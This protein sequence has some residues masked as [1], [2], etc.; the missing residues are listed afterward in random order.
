MFEPGDVVRLRDPLPETAHD[1][2]VVVIVLSHW[3]VVWRSGEIQ[4]FN[5][6]SGDDLLVERD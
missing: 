4:H 5:S 3:W 6:I 1:R 2:G